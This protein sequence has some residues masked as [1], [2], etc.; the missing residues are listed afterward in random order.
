MRRYY[1]LIVI[2]CLFLLL[3]TGCAANLP[4]KPVGEYIW[5]PPPHVPKIKWL[6]QWSNQYDF[7]KPNIIATVLAGEDIAKLSRPNG[8][9]VDSSG[10]I[11]AAD[12]DLGV[13]FVFDQEQHTLRVI[14]GGLLGFPVGVAIDNSTGILY[15]T[16][17]K[18]DVII[19]I[20]KKDG[21]PLLVV[22][23]LGEFKNPSGIVV[24]EARDRFYV[25]D[26]QNHIV[27]VFTRAG[28]PLFNIGEKGTEE[29]KFI[30][31]SFLALDKEGRLYVS[32]TFNFRVQIFSP[33]GKFIKTFGK[34]GDVSGTFSRPKGIGVDSDGH[35]YV[36][37]A[38]FNNFQ[39]FDREGNLL[40]WVGGGGSE[41]GQFNLPAG[42][43]IDRH[44][45]IYISDTFNRRIQ[46]FQY[47]KQK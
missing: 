24:D 18:L 23:K 47:L 43:F 31:P 13:I 19:G 17:S 25:T 16:D 26:T 35:I 1:L 8:V 21:K 9:V 27:R 12:S 42:L 20:D 46:V 45:R 22:G 39:I 7:G 37:D 40:L 34:L 29:G 28:N 2:W 36:V 30:F 4:E 14:G 11:Y 32:D 3:L 10:N 44:D 5:P 41:P 33:D 6:T 15:V 38:A